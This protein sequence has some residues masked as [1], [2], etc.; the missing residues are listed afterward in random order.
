MEST[1]KQ[2]EKQR[3]AERWGAV[4]RSVVNVEARIEES[5]KSVKDSI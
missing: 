4:Q 3:E 1:G 2:R 5:L